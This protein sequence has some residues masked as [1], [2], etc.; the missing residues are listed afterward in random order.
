MFFPLI[1]GEISVILVICL[2]SAAVGNSAEAGGLLGSLFPWVLLT[3]TTSWAD[4]LYILPF[5]LAVWISAMTDGNQ[6]VI[7]GTGAAVLGVHLLRT[8]MKYR[9]WCPSVANPTFSKLD[10]SEHLL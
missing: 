10:E 2:V 4:V 8:P 6:W 1:H 5:H 9:V 7:F 3:A